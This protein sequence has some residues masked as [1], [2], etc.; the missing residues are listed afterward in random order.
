MKFISRKHSLKEILENFSRQKKKSTQMESQRYGKKWKKRQKKKILNTCGKNYEKNNS[1]VGGDDDVRKVTQVIN[2]FPFHLGS[3]ACMRAKSLQWCWTLCNLMNCSPPDS[4]VHGILQAR[5][6]EW[7][8]ISFS[9]G[10]SWPR[11]RTHISYVSW[12]GRQVLYH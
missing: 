5:T 3:H 8:A 10:S 7:V 11:D 2:E 9:R 12:I 1:N 6:L 4:S